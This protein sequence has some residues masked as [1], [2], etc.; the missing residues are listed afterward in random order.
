MI[1]KIINNK[2]ATVIFCITL[3]IILEIIGRTVFIWIPSEGKLQNLKILRDLF[4]IGGYILTLINFGFIDRNDFTINLKFLLPATIAMVVFLYFCTE[5]SEK[6]YPIYVLTEA[7]FMA[8]IAEELICRKFLLESFL[9]KH[10]ILGCIASMVFFI[11][12]HFQTNISVLIFYFI[13]AFLLTVTQIKTKSII[14]SM[15]LH[16]ICNIMI[17]I[18]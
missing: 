4:I 17:Y 5:S 8:P 15:I 13:I 9:P 6:K 14:N 7:F 10:I 16:S 11:F 1:E 12:F 18:I 3:Y 2:F